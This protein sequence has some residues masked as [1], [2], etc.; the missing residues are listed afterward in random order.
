MSHVYQNIFPR[1]R[2]PDGYPDM[3]GGYCTKSQKGLC[4]DSLVTSSARAMKDE[5]SRGPI[6]Q[7]KALDTR[8]LVLGLTGTYPPQ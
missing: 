7:N 3:T 8:F 6:A 4:G 5:R 2:E 1:C